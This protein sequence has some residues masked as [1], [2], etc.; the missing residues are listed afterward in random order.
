MS[1]ARRAAKTRQRPEAAQAHRATKRGPVPKAESIPQPVLDSPATA[2]VPGVLLHGALA[3]SPDEV[4]A[5]FTVP[6]PSR[7]AA[8]RPP[9]PSS[10][11]SAIVEGHLQ[12]AL[13]DTAETAPE[14]V[15]QAQVDVRLDINENSL[16]TLQ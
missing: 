15:S 5:A 11:A 3:P 4:G 9:Q 7:P 12:E 8:Q 10:A 14:P 2:M 13:A 6:A 1:D 16:F